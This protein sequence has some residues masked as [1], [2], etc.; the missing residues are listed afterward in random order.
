MAFPIK[1]NT[2]I[3]TFRSLAIVAI[4]F[5]FGDNDRPVGTV[6]HWKVMKID[7]ILCVQNCLRTFHANKSIR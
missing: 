1:K 2:A 3:L 4:S 6:L 5:P 7:W